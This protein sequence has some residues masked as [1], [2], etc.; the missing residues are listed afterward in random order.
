MTFT[1]SG[2]HSYKFHEESL[3]SHP[4]HAGTQKEVELAIMQ[5]ALGRYLENALPR[6]GAAGGIADKKHSVIVN[7]VKV[8][9]VAWSPAPG[10]NLI[11]ISDY[12]AVDVPVLGSTAL[13]L[14]EGSRS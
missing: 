1:I 12:M 14:Q 6:S 3:E 4:G 7:G 11:T 10:S 5:Q 13:D 8:V 9:Y 2:G